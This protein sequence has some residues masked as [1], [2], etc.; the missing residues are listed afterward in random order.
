[1]TTTNPAASKSIEIFIQ[2]NI[3]ASTP[4]VFTATDR[5]SNDV[6]VLRKL[7]KTGSHFALNP[8]TKGTRNPHVCKTRKRWSKL[9]GR[10]G[11]IPC[12]AR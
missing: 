9:W 7:R 1:M 3:A 8:Q 6:R 12:P 4:D 5:S 11:E 10:T 2:P